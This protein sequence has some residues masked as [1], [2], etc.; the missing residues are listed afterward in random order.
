MGGNLGLDLVVH[1]TPKQ[2]GED[3]DG[4]VMSSATVVARLTSP[5]YDNANR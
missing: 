3:D 2:K 5:S 4:L 1:P